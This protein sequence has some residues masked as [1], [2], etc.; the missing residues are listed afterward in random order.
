MTRGRHARR[1]IA[2]AARIAGTDGSLLTRKRKLA[3]R[4]PATDDSRFR[5]AHLRHDLAADTALVELHHVAPHFRLTSQEADFRPAATAG[6][7]PP[8]TPRIIREIRNEVCCRSNAIEDCPV[9]SRGK[10]RTRRAQPT[11]GVERE[12]RV[13]A[14]C[15]QASTL[16]PTSGSSDARGRGIPGERPSGRRRKGRLS[17][18]RGS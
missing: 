5:T 16:R 8:L 11:R 10:V 17:R 6:P 7:E 18:C 2:T 9:G 15:R 12:R 4:H 14:A 13:N 1:P 3:H